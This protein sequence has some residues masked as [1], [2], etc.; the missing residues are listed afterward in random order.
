MDKSRYNLITEYLIRKLK[1][2]VSC[3]D[4]KTGEVLDPVLTDAQ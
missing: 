2:N 4:M 1:V 3:V